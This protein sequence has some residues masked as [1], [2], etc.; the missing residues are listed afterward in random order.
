MIE[1]YLAASGASGNFSIMTTPSITDDT[2]LN[3][4]AASSARSLNP[5]NTGVP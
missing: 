4:E 5:N 2:D 3:S 1:N